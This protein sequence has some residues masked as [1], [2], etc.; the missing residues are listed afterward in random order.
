MPSHALPCLAMW[1]GLA[2]A[3]ANRKGVCPGYLPERRRRMVEKSSIFFPP[4]L[5]FVESTKSSRR[6]PP[7]PFEE[8]RLDR[9]GTTPSRIDFAEAKQPMVK[10]AAVMPCHA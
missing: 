4:L 10:L 6:D 9:D 3:E 7:R 5:P 8:G 1:Q 2:E